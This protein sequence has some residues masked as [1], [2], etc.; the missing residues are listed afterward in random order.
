MASVRAHGRWLAFLSFAAVTGC[1]LNSEGDL[2]FQSGSGGSAGSAGAAGGSVGGS[3]G[4]PDGAGGGTSDS[5]PGTDAKSESSGDATN[6]DEMDAAAESA[7][8]AAP[9]QLADVAPDQPIDAAPDTADA[10]VDTTPEAAID[11]PADGSDSAVACTEPNAR[12]QNGHCYFAIT[13]PNGF[14]W[15]EA[16]QAC[17]AVG[18]HLVVLTA[19]LESTF[20]GHFGGVYWIG[21]FKPT[22]N[23]PWEWVNGEPFAYTFWAPGEPNGSGNCARRTTDMYCRD[24]NCADRTGLDTNG[25]VVPID[26]LCER[27]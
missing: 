13:A 7:G 9:D 16:K 18:A 1:G 8:E 5:N 6:G 20:V 24:T 14:T 12:M 3:G 21:A 2:L 23:S 22:F 17:E 25:S 4:S 11:A 27:P 15:S 19:V 10:S 26:A